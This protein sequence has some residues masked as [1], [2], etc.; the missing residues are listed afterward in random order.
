M[1]FKLKNREFS[2]VQLRIG[3][4]VFVAAAGA[5]LMEISASRMIAPIVGVSLYTWT[6]I[7]AVVLAGMSSGNWY[8]GRLADRPDI[9]KKGHVYVAVAF[10]VAAIACVLALTMTK[11]MSGLFPNGVGSVVFIVC[12]IVLIPSFAL[13]V[14]TPVLMRVALIEQAAEP[15]RIIGRLYALGSLGAITGTVAAGYLFIPVIGIYKTV[16]CTAVV[17]AGLAF[18]T[19]LAAGEKR[20]ATVTAISIVAALLFAGRAGGLS[21]NCVDESQYYCIDVREVK[22]DLYGDRFNG[23]KLVL[24]RLTHGANARDPFAP[25]YYEYVSMMNAL[26]GK[27]FGEKK[28]ID[29]FFIGGGAYTL[30]RALLS[31]RPGS[32]IAVAEID[33][34]V[35]EA[36]M[37]HLFLKPHENLRIH[38]ADARTVLRDEDMFFSFDVIVGDAFHDIAPP[39]HLLTLEFQQLVER[40]LDPQGMYVLNIIDNNL[41][42]RFVV[43][44]ATTLEQVF[45][46]VHV[47]RSVGELKL[48]SESSNV[49]RETFV[50]S[51]SQRKLNNDRRID[52]NNKNGKIRSFARWAWAPLKN[53]EH[54]PVLTD[55]FAPVEHLLRTTALAGM[56]RAP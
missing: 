47:W 51:A 1:F 31:R 5:M 12:S 25:F 36:A 17:L 16:V 10:M 27:N 21:S 44:V 55:D 18:F 46:N 38:H 34:A 14:S 26:V 35:T 3:A 11:N 8:G 43:S 45:A 19:A 20:V 37:K 52:T 32:R 15:G 33:P 56:V 40:R 41:D 29:A 49:R 39:T 24:D 6:T 23:K 22:K 4:S 48:L 2:S 50:I 53:R 28:A 9:E 13:G 7:I 30:P 54:S 42:P